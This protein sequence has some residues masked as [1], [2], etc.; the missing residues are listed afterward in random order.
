[1]LGT[2]KNSSSQGSFFCKQKAFNWPCF[3]SFC[4][5]PPPPF[6]FEAMGVLLSACPSIEDTKLESRI[7]HKLHGFT[8]TDLEQSLNLTF[9]LGNSW[10]LK[11]GPFVLDFHT[12][13]LVLKNYCKPPP[14]PPHNS[15]DLWDVQKYEWKMLDFVF[16][17]NI[18]GGATL[19]SDLIYLV[20]PAFI[21]IRVRINWW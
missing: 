21:T 13:V 6:S 16:R 5:P 19:Y 9:V 15:C 1:M 8:D 4:T 7:S 14:P 17:F 12:H 18:S 3:L 10:N 20:I 2:L 11:N